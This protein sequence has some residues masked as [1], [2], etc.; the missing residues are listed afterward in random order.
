MIEKCETVLCL[1]C[2]ECCGSVDIGWALQFTWTAATDTAVDA[3]IEDYQFTVDNGQTWNTLKKTAGTAKATI[4][5]ID[6]LHYPFSEQNSQ[7][8]FLPGTTH[9]IRMRSVSS[10]TSQEPE[11]KEY[12]YSEPSNPA[13]LMVLGIT[14]LRNDRVTFVWERPTTI[15]SIAKCQ[16][17]KDKGNSW[18]DVP[19]SNAATITYTVP[20]LEQNKVYDFVVRA[21]GSSDT[22][23]IRTS[24]LSTPAKTSTELLESSET[25]AENYGTV[26]VFDTASRGMWTYSPPEIYTRPTGSVY[27]HY[28]EVG[29]TGFEPVTSSMSRKHSN[30]LS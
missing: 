5:P 24:V 10:V 22:E 4:N 29:D 28:S 27:Y 23:L 3:V 14:E 17:S 8:D 13:D 20:N 16:Y 21:L 2:I 6:D 1:W 9:T 19:N 26:Y 11:T 7:T 15:P 12:R 18:T 30:Q 25:D